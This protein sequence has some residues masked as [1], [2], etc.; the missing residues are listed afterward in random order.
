MEP[1]VPIRVLRSLYCATRSTSP[2]SVKPRHHPVQLLAV[3]ARVGQQ[4]GAV[5]DEFD[6]SGDDAVDVELALVPPTGCV[7]QAVSA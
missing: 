3:G 7:C 1:S 6:E 2:S 5:G 4:G